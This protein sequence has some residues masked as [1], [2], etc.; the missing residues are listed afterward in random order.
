[1]ISIRQLARIAKVSPG[2]IS[3]VLNEDP[4]LSVSDSTRKRV[5]TLIKQYNYQPTKHQGKKWI[6]SLCV[7][8]TLTEAEE[9]N[10]AYFRLI[11]QGV[12]EAAQE[13][14]FKIKTIYRLQEKPKMN[15][16]PKYAGLI[17]IGAID[18]Q[19][20]QS[21]R[22]QNEHLVLIDNQVNTLVANR[23]DPDVSGMAKTAFQRFMDQGI[24]E[25]GFVGG[26]LS[27]VGV[28]GQVSHPEKEDRLDTFQ[29]LSEAE[30]GVTLHTKI[31]EWSPQFG[32]DSATTLIQE[33]PQIQAFV[34]ASDPIAL[35]VLR[36]L[37]DLKVSVPNQVQ[38][39]GF[40]DLNYS[41]FLIPR[42]STFRIPTKEIGSE[43]VRILV[44]ELTSDNSNI[45]QVQ[46]S[47]K[48]I[49][50]ETTI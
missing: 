5:L 46:L 38:V 21:F 4:T 44:H 29:Q 40:D 12:S 37:H 28:Q 25:F 34:A 42:L 33:H 30:A 8:T 7:I 20:V 48:L 43:A 3:R 31:G 49:E 16:I 18:N 13:T 45:R 1:M 50:R 39:I 35:G 14:D 47:G 26:R 19:V 11:F 36:A 6:N 24:K 2:V 32:Y 27:S 23:V 17:L 15:D 9:V 10:D 22:D 41:K